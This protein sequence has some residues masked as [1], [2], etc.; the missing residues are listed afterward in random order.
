MAVVHW[1]RAADAAGTRPMLPRTPFKELPMR[2]L[3]ALDGS[4]S[5]DAACRVVDAL[6]WPA[7]TSILVLGVLPLPG[8]R[9]AA[10]AG[11]P[12]PEVDDEAL[13]ADLGR[14]IADAAR[15]LADDGR[16]VDRKVDR[17]LVRGRAAT[18]IV[19]EATAW[20]A[21][22]I[23]VGSRGLGR[24]TSMLLGS[25]SAEVVDHA[26]CPVLVTRSAEVGSVLVAVD[27]SRTSRECVEHL[28]LGY[29]ARLPVEVLSVGHTGRGEPGPEQ[30]EAVAAQA[31][32]DLQHTGHGVRWTIATG[33]PAQEIIRAADE[34]GC[35][36][37]AMGSRGHTGL[38][39]I[40][41][42]SVARNVLL[43]TR[44][45]VLI[46]R[47]PVPVRAAELARE[48]ARDTAGARA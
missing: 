46:V 31:A 26:R 18:C 37:I 48:A 3:L 7:G 42:G 4:P 11:M 47:G 25:V 14:V 22:L 13:D 8:L 39:R 5:S 19:D 41:L 45:S 35:D 34:L 29:L 20:G 24:L 43:H 10:L 44:A 17:R 40:R 6:A 12:V 23:V 21:E 27:G 28:G 30:P 1:S 2:V 38:A 32:E 15:S 33:D 9:G 16:R 36:L